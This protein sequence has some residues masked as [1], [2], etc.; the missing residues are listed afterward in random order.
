M[1]GAERSDQL[2]ISRAAN[3]GHVRTQCLG[4]LHSERAHASRGPVDQNF[5]ASLNSA[6][7][8]ETLQGGKPGD[9]D[10]ASLLHRDV[11]GLHHQEFLANSDILREGPTFS[12][13]DFVAWFE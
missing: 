9:L 5:L 2:N 11:S 10:T 12:A 8:A 7:V 4:D 13:E 3:T 6:L 1:I